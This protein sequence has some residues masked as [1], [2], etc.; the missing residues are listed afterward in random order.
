MKGIRFIKNILPYSVGEVAHF[1]EHEAL[2]LVK[3][4]AA[5]FVEQKK[6]DAASASAPAPTAPAKPPAPAK[7]AGKAEG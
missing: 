5:E 6:P 2:R 7:V 3:S 4:G 1:P